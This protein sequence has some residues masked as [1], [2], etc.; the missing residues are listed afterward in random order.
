MVGTILNGIIW[1]NWI[2]LNYLISENFL[3]IDYIK[4]KS[5]DVVIYKKELNCRNNYFLKF[6][7]HCRCTI[8]RMVQST[9]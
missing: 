3:Y 2:E 1:I 5:I 4:E 7:L 9:P 8:Y 6:F